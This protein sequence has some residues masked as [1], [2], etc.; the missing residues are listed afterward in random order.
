MREIIF[1]RIIVNPVFEFLKIFY[2]R[3]NVFDIQICYVLQTAYFIKLLNFELVIS[4]L[5][6]DPLGSRILSLRIVL[7]EFTFFRAFDTLSDAILVFVGQLSFRK[8]HRSDWSIGLPRIFHAWYH[9]LWL[10]ILDFTFAL[11][12]LDFFHLFQIVFD[13]VMA[14]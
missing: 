6:L 9:S 7:W 3:R 2:Q 4:D 1:N 13:F 10:F 12:L 11:V 8:S 5:F 14:A